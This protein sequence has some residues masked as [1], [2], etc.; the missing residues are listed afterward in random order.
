[1]ADELHGSANVATE[2]STPALLTTMGVDTPL[3]HDRALGVETAHP[4][5][6]AKGDKNYEGACRCGARA[7][8]KGGWWMLVNR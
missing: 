7:K 4:F 5:H 2:G 8:T 1:M 3:A 6:V